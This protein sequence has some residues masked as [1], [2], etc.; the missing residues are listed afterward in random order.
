[1]PSECQPGGQVCPGP[2]APSPSR[3]SFSGGVWRATE[4]PG[5][6]S[7]DCH[8]IWQQRADTADLLHEIA[9]DILHVSLHRG[10]LPGWIAMNQPTRP[11]FRVR[12]R[13][14]PLLATVSGL[15]GV[16]ARAR[17]GASCRRWLRSDCQRAFRVLSVS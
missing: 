9:H 13:G 2:Q 15:A 7:G 1:V 5:R 3:P 4:N 12:I 8:S 14:P 6:L 11:R 17:R 16:R 10:S